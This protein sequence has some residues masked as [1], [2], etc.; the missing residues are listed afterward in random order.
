MSGCVDKG[1]R[2]QSKQDAVRSEVTPTQD[3]GDV[4]IEIQRYMAPNIEPA[5]FTNSFGEM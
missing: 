2:S 1:T 4:Y 5:P 3:A